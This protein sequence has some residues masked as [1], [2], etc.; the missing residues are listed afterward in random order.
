MQPLGQKKIHY[1]GTKTCWL[2]VLTRTNDS[3]LPSVGCM[4]YPVTVVTVSP[5]CIGG[6]DNTKECTKTNNIG[7]DV[8]RGIIIGKYK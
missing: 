5:G 1:F 6:A 7:L 2:L 3:P 8:V 4:L